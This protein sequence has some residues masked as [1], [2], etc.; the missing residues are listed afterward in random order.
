MQSLYSTSLFP[1]QTSKLMFHSSVFR[2]NLHI[3]MF[4]KF[5][6]WPC[7]CQILDSWCLI[8]Y[9]YHT[10]NI[11]TIFLVLIKAS[12]ID[13]RHKY[14]ILQFQNFLVKEQVKQVSVIIRSLRNDDE[15]QKQLPSLLF[16]GG[17]FSLIQP[18]L[19]WKLV[20]FFI[21]SWC[22]W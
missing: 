16:F 19:C 18:R 15:W 13:L 22:I 5:Q 1:T 21:L 8:P 17:I 4:L 6:T 3:A 7:F 11:T 20:L 14:N 12:F 10:L 9:S 2:Q